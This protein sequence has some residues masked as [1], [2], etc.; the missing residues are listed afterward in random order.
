MSTRSGTSPWRASSLKL[1]VNE[2]VSFPET[3]S[4]VGGRPRSCVCI[5]EP[6]AGFVRPRLEHSGCRRPMRA[7]CGGRRKPPFLGLIRYCCGVDASVQSGVIV[8]DGAP[9]GAGA[10]VTEDVDAGVIMVG[11]PARP[12]SSRPSGLV[13]LR[14]G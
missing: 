8:G 2:A 7:S 5:K 12:F 9:I 3:P 4:C 10:V 6:V 13:L 14:N 11:V 1:P